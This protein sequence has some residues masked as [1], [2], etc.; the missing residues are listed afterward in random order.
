MRLVKT[1]L[2]DNHQIFIE[3]LKTVLQHDPNFHHHVVGCTPSGQELL[4]LW[5][6]HEP[7][8]LIMDLNLID[9]NGLD[10]ISRIRKGNKDMP[11]I[12]VMT[13]HREPKIIRAILE[14]GANGFL[15]KHKGEEELYEA[16][17]TI[18]EGKIYKAEAVSNGMAKLIA[19]QGPS[20]SHI[21]EGFIQKHH[22]TKREAQILQLISQAMSNKEIGRKLFISDQT[23]SVHRKNI[24]RKLGVRSTAGL[25]KMTYEHSF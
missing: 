25:M 21:S 5:Q 2:G 22:L 10:V 19:E 6:E 9:K 3:G 18:F 1:L 15:P 7:D 14:K 4:E 20:G 17:H 24:M 11:C 23:V 13:A 16:I 12:L 8:L